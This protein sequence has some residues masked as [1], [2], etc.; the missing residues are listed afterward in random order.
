[1]LRL[2]SRSAGWTSAPSIRCRYPDLAS[3]TEYRCTGGEQRQGDEH[4]V[5]RRAA[6]TR[7]V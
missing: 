5:R 7:K 1:M 3:R 4:D 6:G 2:Y